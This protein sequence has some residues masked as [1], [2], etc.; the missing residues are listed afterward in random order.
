MQAMSNFIKKLEEYGD[1][2]VSIIR[3]TKINKVLKALIK[4][5]S[6]PKDEE[7]QFRHRSHE[8]LSKWNS[9]L[10][11]EPA[12]TSAAPTGKESPAAD[13]PTTNGAHA[14]EAEG[15]KEKVEA[16]AAATEDADTKMEDATEA[17]GVEVGESEKDAPA[18]AASKAEKPA[19][20][21][22]T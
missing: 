5:D 19:A 10:G 15:D 14:E 20:E 17:K 18:D 13:K 16:R 2:E 4:L 9:L 21:A 1:L 22:A 7:F 8:L 6:I 11:T 3:T 12:P